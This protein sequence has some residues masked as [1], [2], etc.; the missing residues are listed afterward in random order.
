MLAE[1]IP[2][3]DFACHSHRHP[4]GSDIYPLPQGI[5]I[6]LC[7]RCDALC[8]LP[9]LEPSDRFDQLHNIRFNSVLIAIRTSRYAYAYASCPEMEPVVHTAS[10][11]ALFLFPRLCI[12]T[13]VVGSVGSRSAVLYACSGPLGTL[14]RD[15]RWP[16]IFANKEVQ[17]ITLVW[18][19]RSVIQ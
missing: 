5:L 11:F 7:L 19:R 13:V 6:P 1:Q 3:F 14:T 15:F 10:P 2:K 4:N 8:C 16:L 17:L 12:S 18:S 9:P